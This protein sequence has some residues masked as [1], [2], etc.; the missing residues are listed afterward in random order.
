VRLCAGPVPDGAGFFCAPG[1]FAVGLVVED[2]FVG[3]FVFG[4]EGDEAAP[5]LSPAGIFVE[6]FD[7]LVVGVE[8]V[9]MAGTRGEL[10][11]HFA[12]HGFEDRFSE[13]IEEVGYGR[14]FGELE[15]GDVLAEDF[16]GAAGEAGGLPGADVFLGDF[17][18]GG[19]EFYAGDFAEGNT[20][21]DEQASAH[22]G[23]DVEEG[24]V[25]GRGYEGG[26]APDG[27]ELFQD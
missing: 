1:V 15:F 13:G 16:H 17:A 11:F 3:F 19:V 20:G 10:G 7:A 14:V 4:R 27:D 21:G 9:E 8:Q 25:F 2:G 12:Q 18:E 24:V 26:V 23:S 6:D 5:E 22:A